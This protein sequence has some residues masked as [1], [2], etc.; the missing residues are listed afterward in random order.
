MREL[1]D[2]SLILCFELGT[3]ENIADLK[4]SQISAKKK[5][6]RTMVAGVLVEK[7]LI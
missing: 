7:S 5:F 3:F 1:S 4:I 2:C 6:C